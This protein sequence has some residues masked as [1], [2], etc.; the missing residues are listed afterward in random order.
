MARATPS[1]RLKGLTSGTSQ[2][3]LPVSLSVTVQV[4]G[5][6]TFASLASSANLTDAFDNIPYSTFFV[7]SNG[8][9]ANADASSPSAG[10]ASLLE[11]HVIPNFVGYLPSLVNGSTL[12]TQAGSLVTVTI[13]GEN[14]Y[15]NDAM[16]VSSNLI[17]ENGVAHVIDKVC[18][19][20]LT[21]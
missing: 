6:S 11:G 9:F 4:T 14:Y 7:P 21:P 16:I 1:K 3:T 20:L 13:Q 18:L 19:F 8:A 2:F 15:I 10:T 17:L 12:T 5:E